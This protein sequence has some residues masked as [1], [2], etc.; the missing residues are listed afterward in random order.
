M[1]ITPLK[2]TSPPSGRTKVR[3][4]AGRGRYDRATIH[5]ILDDGMYG[6]VGVQSGGQPFVIPTLYGRFGDEV[7]LHGSPLAGI[8]GV[9]VA[10]APLCLT[11]TLLDGLVLARSAFHHSMN[12]RSVVILGHAR[13][14]DDREGKLEA[15]RV[16]VDH[17]IPG[18]SEDVRG[19]ND[20]ELAATEVVALDLNEASAKIRTGP[21]IDGPED[22]SIPAW[23]GEVPLSLVT[24]SPVPDE[25]CVAPL[26]TYVT[27]YHRPNGHGPAAA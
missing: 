25:G 19:P 5:A 23:A 27:S 2:R 11:V 8:L 16:I 12:Y 7:F 4:H 20:K 14:I 6:H 24:G 26:P 21:P 10:G 22:R 9:A 15:L 18:R 3:R 17:V 13:R 1:S